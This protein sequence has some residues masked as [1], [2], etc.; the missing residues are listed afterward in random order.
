[1]SSRKKW[2]TACLAA[3]FLLSG[4]SPIVKDVPRTTN[5][6]TTFYPIYA[7][8]E[9][10][11]EGVEDVEIHCLV[12][13][14]AACL[15]SYDL[16]D[17]DLYLLGYSADVVLSAGNGLESFEDKLYEIGES[18]LP[19]AEVLYGVPMECFEQVVSDDESHFSGENPHV[20]MSLSN[21]SAI[22]DNI[23]GVL[24]ILDSENANSYAANCVAAQERLEQ[25]R[26]D[27][28]KK[29]EV[30]HGIAAAVMHEALLY[31]A[32]ECGLEIAAVCEHES[33]EMLYDSGIEE[34]LAELEEKKIQV[35]LLE[36][37]APKALV[38]VLTE[39]GYAVV[40][41]DVLSTYSENKGAEGYVNALISNAQ[42]IAD[43][44]GNLLS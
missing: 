22:L 44:C 17:W 10:I 8:T 12:Q 37:Q 31:P 14:Q 28:E 41:L 39:A 40:Q 19:V 42:R 7:L 16:S 27:V 23:A 34:C 32:L 20:Y 15:R 4:C 26:T 1:M 24:S 25:V 3:V 38:E 13:P 29:T 11:A 21:A 36:Q 35:V 43:A 5:I 2:M 30:C 9:Q 6:Y 33:G 18:V